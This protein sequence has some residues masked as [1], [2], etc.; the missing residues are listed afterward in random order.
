MAIEPAVSVLPANPGSPDWYVNRLYDE[1]MARRDECDFY[2]DYYSGDHPLP[3]LAPQ[4][5]DEFRRILGMTRTNYMGL[6]VDSKAER[7]S[8]E[9]F[10]F[11]DQAQGDDETFELY[12]HNNMDVESDQAISEAYICGESFFF[13]APNPGNPKIPYWGTE[14]AANAIV[15]YEPGTR[16]R[17]RKAG[18]KLWR[19]EYT[20]LLNAT[21]FLRVMDSLGNVD[22]R[23]YK[24]QAEDRNLGTRPRFERRVVTGEDW[25]A[26][27]QMDKIPLVPILNNPR[28]RTGGR[29]ELYDLTDIQD[30]INKTVA[31]RLMTQDYGAFPQKWAVAWPDED[32]AGNPNTIDIGR[33]RMVTTEVQETK[34]GQWETAPLDPYSFA[35]REDVKDIASR[36]RVPAQYLLGEMNNVNGETLKA[37]E[38]GLVATVRHQMKYVAEAAEESARMVRDLA[39]LS[40]V[41]DHR[42]ETIFS[43]PEFRTEGE[44][45][46]AAVKKLQVGIATRRQARVDVGYSETAI[47]AMEADD[48]REQIHPLVANALREARTSDGNSPPVGG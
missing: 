25:G 6:V 45:T 43:N 42:M 19:D 35:K 38:A 26:S 22:I 21:V 12:Q 2:E 24:Y 16:R 8:I 46:D 9:G 10:R 40:N 39:G 41:N 15:A 30:R 34:F 28:M 32:E 14:S 4:A 29:S 7:I 11:G 31:D 1:L 47:Q 27:G 18:M 13:V 3:W 48:V 20:N 23:V 44:V 33:N 37:S 17:V 5:R 36:S